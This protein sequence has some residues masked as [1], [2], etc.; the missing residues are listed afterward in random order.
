MRRRHFRSRN[1]FTLIELLVVIAIIGILIGLLLPA[2]QKVRE[3]ANRAKCQN[4]LKQLGIALHN[5]HSAF[6]SF[7]YGGKS[8][9][10]CAGTTDPVAY[11]ANGLVLLLPYIE[12]TALFQEWDPTSASSTLNHGTPGNGN[13][14][15]PPAGTAAGQANN[16]QVESNPIPLLH[17]PADPGIPTA[18]G[19]PWYTPSSAATPT[20]YMSN[21]DFIAFASDTGAIPVPLC[22]IWQ[23]QPTDQRYMFGE[24][25][26]TR[27]ADVLDGT[28]NTMAMGEMVYNCIN[29]RTSS[30][31]YRGWVQT[32]IDPGN[33]GI[34][35]WTSGT[36]G[37]ALKW[38][39]MTS[40]HPSGANC[41][42]ADGSVHFVSENT[43]LGVLLQLCCMADGNTPQLP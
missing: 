21:Y 34:N 6:D 31:G 12:Q 37:Q 14:T 22:H 15:P 7:P 4:N 36:Y 38:G 32:G 3:A 27:V 5:Y 19:A 39:H 9:G 16:A 24:N 40:M 18:N 33:F 20:G 23:K 41:L 11:N 43:S 42:F 2:V 25:S 8:Y 13:T 28:S 26:T 30:W 10:W 1:G 29:G 17:C 35:V